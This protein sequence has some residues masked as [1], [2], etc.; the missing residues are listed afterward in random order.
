VLLSSRFLVEVEVEMGDLVVVFRSRAWVARDT[1]ATRR[2]VAQLR[3][4]AVLV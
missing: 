3:I 1:I 4:A 2:I